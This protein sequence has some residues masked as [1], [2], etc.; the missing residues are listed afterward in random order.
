M[1][2]TSFVDL[3][4]LEVLLCHAFNL[5]SWGFFL[6]RKFRQL[7]A[8]LNVAF[9]NLFDCRSQSF[10]KWVKYTK[11]EDKVIRACNFRIFTVL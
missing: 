3:W 2:F 6:K 9:M 10:K 11:T 4:L 5:F 1:C 8:Y 7:F